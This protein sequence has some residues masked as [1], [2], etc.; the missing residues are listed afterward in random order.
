MDREK[1]FSRYNLGILYI[2]ITAMMH[3]Y[4]IGGDIKVNLVRFKHILAHF[5]RKITD[6]FFY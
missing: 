4:V 1:Y 2:L 6:M 5:L 3:L